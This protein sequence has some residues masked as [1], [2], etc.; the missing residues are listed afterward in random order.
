MLEKELTKK[1]EVDHPIDITKR[2][3]AV[4]PNKFKHISLLLLQY[5]NSNWPNNK[6]LWLLRCSSKCWKEIMLQLRTKCSS[7]FPKKL[8]CHSKCFSKVQIYRIWL[9]RLLWNQMIRFILSNWLLLSLLL[10]EICF[11]KLWMKTLTQ[12]KR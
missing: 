6:L 12:T 5:L 9:T 1:K 4:H 7:I 8:V 3:L 11:L 10:Q 2:R